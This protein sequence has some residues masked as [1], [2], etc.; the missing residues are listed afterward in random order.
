MKILNAGD[1]P[2]SNADVLDW[3][4]RKKAQH[5]RDDA[6]EKAQGHKRSERPKNFMRVLERTE[7]ELSSDKYPYKKNPSAY[8]G[9]GRS[10]A[11]K[12]FALEVERVIQDALDAE[13]KDRLAGMPATQIEKEFEP[14]QERKCLTHPELLVIYNHAP[15][16]VEMLQPMIE[17]VEE[18][19][20]PEEQQ[21]IVDVIV[22]HLRC[23]ENGKAEP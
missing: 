3:V 4:A 20:T 14:V 11:F 18:R 9:D 13:W 2:L 23:D 15:I 16:C 5:E 17:A 7:R 12:E 22:K 19:F 1:H 8:A 21:L 6:E 10:T